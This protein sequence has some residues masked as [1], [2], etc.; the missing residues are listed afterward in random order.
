MSEELGNVRIRMF[1]SSIIF[2]YSR[3]FEV[4]NMGSGVV[5]EKPPSIEQRTEDDPG[6][7]G[8]GC[9]RG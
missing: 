2:K 7:M 5:P 4:F 6:N 3:K 8:F 1:I 9:Y